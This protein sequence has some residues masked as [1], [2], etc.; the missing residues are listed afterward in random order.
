MRNAKLKEI[1]LKVIFPFKMSALF[2]ER[3]KDRYKIQRDAERPGEK[4]IITT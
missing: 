1:E 2:Q 3:R 4:P